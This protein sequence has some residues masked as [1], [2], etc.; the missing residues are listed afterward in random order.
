MCFGTF[1]KKKT[2]RI[3]RNLE[4]SLRLYKGLECLRKKT[5]NPSI[6]RLYTNLKW[7][8]QISISGYHFWRK[9]TPTNQ[10]KKKAIHKKKRI[11]ED[12]ED[13]EA[14]DKDKLINTVIDD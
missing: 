6:A 2:R 3:F 11:E 14:N 12:S 10:R 9:E 7:S 13:L 1:N 5:G 4:K 8:I